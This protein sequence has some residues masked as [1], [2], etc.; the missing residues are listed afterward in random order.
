MKLL[1]RLGCFGFI[2]LWIALAIFPF[3]AFKLA[4]N[5]QINLANTRIFLLEERKTNG[6][7]VQTVKPAKND[8]SCTVSAVRYYLWK[9]ES[10]NQSSRT[11]YCNDELADATYIADGWSCSIKE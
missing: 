8:A 9:G 1:K 10:E 4:M 5:K 6:I 3:F 2:L 11:C 7:G